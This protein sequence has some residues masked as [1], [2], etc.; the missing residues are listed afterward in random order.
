MAHHWTLIVFFSGYLPLTLTILVSNSSL[1]VEE[2]LVIDTYHMVSPVRSFDMV[3]V[4]VRSTP[5]EP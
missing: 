4:R 3:R 2:R 5:T 1:I